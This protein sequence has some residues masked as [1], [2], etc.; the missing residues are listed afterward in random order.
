MKRTTLLLIALI[1]PSTW[2]FAC[3][4]E[5]LVVAE[6]S[7]DGGS[8]DTSTTDERGDAKVDGETTAVCCPLD[9]A[10]SGCMNL[11]GSAKTGCAKTC[12]FFCSTNW[13]VEQD[14]TGCQVWRW[15]IRTPQAGE[16]PQC[17]SDAG[18]AG[19][20]PA[21]TGDQVCA[22]YLVQGGIPF[23]VDD[24]GV[25]PSG[26]HWNGAICERDPS[27]ACVARP[28]SCG[29]AQLDCGCAE[30]ICASLSSCPFKCSSTT[31]TQ[32]NCNCMAP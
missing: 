7:A 13:R 28:T 3:N 20:N 15:D 29:P 1:L 5:T 22:K 31:S 21:C 14:D 16:T 9:P 26:S 2:I 27:Y 11:G 10:P 32:V 12:D 8:P 25:C 17:F 30:S 24:A 18:S 6:N 4:G 23:P 19:C